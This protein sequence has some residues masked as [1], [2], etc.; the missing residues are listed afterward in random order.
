MTSILLVD[1]DDQFRTMLAEV[2]TVAGYDVREASDGNQGTRLYESWPADLLITD[3]VMP[4]KEGLEMILEMKRMH[5][6]VKIIAISGGGRHGSEDYLKIAMA[7][8]AERVL[9]KPFSHWEILEA[10]KQ[11]LNQ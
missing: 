2:L 3:L 6:G 1:D 4:D 5:S 9:A 10:I 11:V 8:G 7:F